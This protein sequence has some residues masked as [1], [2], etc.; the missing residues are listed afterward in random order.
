MEVYPQLVPGLPQSGGYI[1]LLTA[2]ASGHTALSV[3]VSKRSHLTEAIQE[4]VVGTPP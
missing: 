2:T 4:Q 3:A 1:C